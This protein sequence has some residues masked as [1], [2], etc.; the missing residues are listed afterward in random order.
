MIYSRL[1]NVAV[2][3]RRW[4]STDSLFVRHKEFLTLAKD[5]G[6]GSVKLQQRGKVIEILI[7]NQK[8]RNAISGNMMYQLASVVQS[9][10]DIVRNDP[11]VVGLAIRGEGQDTF[12]SGADLEFA[13]TVLNS[14]A[15]GV[16]MARFMTEA[17]NSLRQSSLISVCCLN[18]TVV[19]GGS[20]LATVGDYRI[21]T[22][23]SKCFLQF[24]HATIGAAPGWGG[25]TRLTNIVGRKE[26]IKL[27]SSAQRITAQDAVNIG[28]VDELE[29]ISSDSDWISVIDEFFQPFAVLKYP[30][31]VRAIK[32]AIAGSEY[33]STAECV[34][35]EIAMFAGRWYS[36][37]HKEVMDK[38]LRKLK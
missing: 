35:N 21:M 18:G 2:K 24:V 6:D 30:K 38:I 32:K 37:D 23:N 9:V 13:G 31:S 22:D 16:L 14:P 17:L 8:K 10:H 15:N 28:F 3:T 25:A 29:A 20:E 7:S 11:T 4:L 33:L 36:D 19:G 5:Q 1:C 12:C 27:A 26:A 34:E